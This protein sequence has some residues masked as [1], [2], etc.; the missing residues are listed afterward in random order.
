MLTQERA[1]IITKIMNS[2]EER[3]KELLGLEPSEALTQIN[4]LGY[5]FTL[6]EI[7]EYGKA[8]K[9][10]SAQN[11]ELNVDALDAVAGGGIIK[12]I[13]VGVVNEVKDFIN[14]WF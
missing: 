6:D 7:K 10:A 2:D 5:D 12:T 14:K 4:A 13:V 1:D 8:L 9:D 11:D 3:A